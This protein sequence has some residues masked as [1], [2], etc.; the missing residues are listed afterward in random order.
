MFA[1]KDSPSDFQH[2]PLDE[3][4]LE[5]SKELE[6]N[7]M[8]ISGRYHGGGEGRDPQLGLLQQIGII[9][10]LAGRVSGED[11]VGVFDGQCAAR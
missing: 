8:A 6:G 10:V 9:D 3:T 4:D 1:F 2:A 11:S 7:C 5:M